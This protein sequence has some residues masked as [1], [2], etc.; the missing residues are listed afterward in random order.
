MNNKKPA[1]AL[2]AAGT[3]LA[4]AIASG[5]AAAQYPV[6]HDVAKPGREILVLR[7]HRL[8]AGGH[9]EF[10]RASR[11]D[12]WPDFERMGARVVGQWKVTRSHVG[13]PAG[14]EEV[15]PLVRYA[16]IEDLE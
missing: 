6:R 11:D 8:Q 16:G 7:N 13:A 2:V 5:F 15:Y 1:H 12:G 10:Y 14:Q 3:F 9:E 4:L